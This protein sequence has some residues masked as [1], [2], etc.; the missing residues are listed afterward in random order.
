M[1]GF[2]LGVYLHTEE[3]TWLYEGG[4]IPEH[5]REEMETRGATIEF[6]RQELE[7]E[8]LQSA[9]EVLVDGGG[10]YMMLRLPELVKVHEGL[11]DKF[12]AAIGRE[13]EVSRG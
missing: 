7:L 8:V 12:S 6:S 3:V 10:V 5:V 2:R 9:F 13:R 11:L 4:D 1:G